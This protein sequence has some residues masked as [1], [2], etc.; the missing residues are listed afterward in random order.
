MAPKKLLLAEDDGDDQQ[1]FR[2]FLVHRRDVTLMP[3]AENGVELLAALELIKHANDLPSIII[4]D[5]NMPRLNGLQTLQILK[6]EKRYSHI[7]VIVYST[8]VDDDLIRESTDKG[9][10]KVVSK[11]F[12]KEGYH[13]MI[14]EFVLSIT[15]HSI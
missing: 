15:K 7:P 3:I 8:Y 2:D 12:T 5:H 13:S 6:R 9:A 10:F 1:L 14:D 4:L 11:P